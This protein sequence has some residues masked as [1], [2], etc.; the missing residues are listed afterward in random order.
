M[1]REGDNWFDDQDRP[2]A[3][4]SGRP[5]VSRRW[6]HETMGTIETRPY[7]T[8]WGWVEAQV[9]LAKELV[10]SVGDATCREFD[11]IEP[12]RPTIGPGERAKKTED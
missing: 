1:R 10:I 6:Q 11:W 3:D 4:R 2:I 7:L 9:W 12:G 5:I 8:H